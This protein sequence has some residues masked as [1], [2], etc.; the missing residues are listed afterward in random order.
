M[1]DLGTNGQDAAPKRRGRRWR[2]VLLGAALI[3]LG[4]ASGFAIGTVKAAPWWMWAGGHHGFN[5]ERMGERV[6]RR[7]DRMLSR[8]EATAE[9]K[10]QVSAIAKGAITD[11]AAL[12]VHPREVRGK[13]LE[14]MRADTIDPAALEALRAEQVAAVDTASKRAVQALTEAASVL[15][16]EQRRE[17]TE[18]WNKRHSRK[19][20]D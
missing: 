6:D 8:V 15:T 16:V 18:R 5:A 20:A 19:R 17:L 4:A 9:Q 10:G 7:V 3:G 11:L 1:T 12:N 2:G 13:F 14:L